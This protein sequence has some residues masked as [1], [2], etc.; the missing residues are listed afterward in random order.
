MYRKNGCFWAEGGGRREG[1]REGGFVMFI[2]SLKSDIVVIRIT[3][4]HVYSCPCLHY[5]CTCI[6]LSLFALHMYMYIPVSVCIT[7]V[8]VYSC[9][10][11][12]YT[13]TCIIILQNV[14]IFHIHSVRRPQVV[15]D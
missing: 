12:H 8:H 15:E 2:Y 6:F 11:L 14:Y 5:T 7:H 3:H 10:C 1:E 4:V 13:C 9:F